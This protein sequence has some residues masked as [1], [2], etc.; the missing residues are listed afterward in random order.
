MLLFIEA[1]AGAVVGL[2]AL[3]LVLRPLGHPGA[4]P[5]E[6]LEPMDFDETPKGV[7]LAALKE[8]EFD[9][10]TGKLSDA[11]Y[12]ALKAKYT[13]AA[14]AALR[15]DDAQ[16]PVADLG[17]SAGAVSCRTCGPRPEADALFCSRCGTRLARTP[18]ASAL[19]ADQPAKAGERT[20][21]VAP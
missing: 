5:T 9:R 15:A 13:A 3:W 2:V 8:I 16:A 4:P 1:V 10:E 18:A 7:A 21:A 6:P 12:E 11:D 20:R 14:L 19:P 17:A